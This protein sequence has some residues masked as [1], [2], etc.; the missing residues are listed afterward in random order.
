MADNTL[1]IKIS[2]NVTGAPDIEKLRAAIA[3]IPGVSIDAGKTAG[4]N[5]RR[6][7][8]EAGE[9]ALDVQELT[10]RVLEL[11]GAYEALHAAYD[12]VKEGV[13][14]N[15]GEDQARLGIAALVASL[16]TV[17]NSQGDVLKGA[18]ALEASYG[19]AADQ[20]EKL[21]ADAI[22]TSAQFEQLLN[23]Y[24]KSIAA[25]SNAGLTLDQ[26]RQIVVGVSQAAGAMGVS[27]DEVGS[28]VRQ[29][30]AGNIRVGSEIAKNLG[31][32]NELVN[33]WKEQ[34]TLVENLT[35]RL[36]VFRVAGAE[37]AKSWGGVTSNIK[38]AITQLSGASTV[39][40]T[41]GLRSGMYDAVQT[42]FDPKTGKLSEDFRGL[43]RLLN[44]ASTA[45][46]TALGDAIRGAAALLKEMSKDAEKNRQ[47][48]EQIGAATNQM[49][50]N[51]KGVVAEFFGLF[52]DSSPPFKTIAA[53]LVKLE[54]GISFITATVRD[55]LAILRAINR[56]DFDSLKSA[57]GFGNT[58][59]ALR[60][61]ADQDA[62]IDRAA[63][64]ANLERSRRSA[65]QEQH[66]D[67]YYKAD[68]EAL[69]RAL[70]NR[71]LTQ[72]E[73][74]KKVEEREKEHVKRLAE[75]RGEKPG[76]SSATST[77]TV[78]DTSDDKDDTA[79]AVA[80][81]RLERTR[82]EN[83]EAQDLNQLAYDE[84]KKSYLAYVTEKKR[85]DLDLLESEKRVY[86]EE[87]TAATKTSEQ[88]KAQGKI[89]VL[90]VQ[91]RIVNARALIEEL[92]A[93]QQQTKAN[94][95]LEKAEAE[96]S[97]KIAQAFGEQELATLKVQ[98]EQRLA[99]YRQYGDAKRSL[100]RAAL[101]AQQVAAR[102]ELD[103]IEKVIAGIADPV[104]RAEAEARQV[105]AQAKLAGLYLKGAQA[106][107]TAPYDQAQE[108]ASDAKRGIETAQLALDQ[109][110]ADIAVQVAQGFL[111]EAQAQ[112]QLNAATEKYLADS[113]KYVATLTDLAQTNKNLAP[114]AQ[115]AAIA[116]NALAN[117]ADKTAQSINASLVTGIQGAFDAVLK[118]SRN[119]GQALKGILLTVAQEIQKILTKDIA[120]QIAGV[121]G[122]G[123]GSN[124]GL[125]GLFSS[126]F[127]G[128]FGG[129]G[130]TA[131]AEFAGLFGFAG[132]GPV[133]G[134]GT[135]TS[136][137]VLA[138]LSRGE[139]V[140]KADAVRSVGQST[141]HH[142]NAHGALPRFAAGGLV[143]DTAP[144]AG[145][146]SSIRIVNVLDK[147]LIEDGLTTPGAEKVFLNLIDK[148]ATKIKQKLG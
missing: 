96:A 76:E 55:L 35:E 124:G 69:R 61:A 75:I 95:D 83:K 119:F 89:D 105:L 18:E 104:K 92:K 3:A 139:Y 106:D 117:Q 48:F 6:V 135:S 118:G 32:S 111:T 37:V 8:K 43:T 114:A 64:A 78:V 107:V 39:G 51:L 65:Q 27:M 60:S 7:G 23:A 15:V 103:G 56:L 130:G 142:I 131:A 24:R 9:S 54:Q 71:D 127:G 85:L 137:S 101:E 133:D 34:G 10:K 74:D 46:G 41:E 147:S 16:T 100:D 102:T 129:G 59:D 91:E 25:G 63:I 98:L 112:A 40:L 29:I 68:N 31:L 36:S 12:L 49:L 45:F 11:V 99:T 136:D 70:A 109:R 126:L 73:Y 144:A 26:T 1:Q 28:A 82:A 21:H 33:Q 77:P 17:K 53:T 134:P 84:Q 115:A 47:I 110:K 30:L 62:G 140:V 113:G 128:A 121:F 2:A 93:R 13:K 38:D 146:G 67:E 19:L 20:V 58:R 79:K 123:S 50:V 44:E 57:A 138:R 132:G 4:E 145:L 66:E 97:A 42:V 86:E 80:E 90:A 72:A 122:S 120:E 143:G 116:F 88:I 87:L 5:L 108:D 141:L 14:Y 22:Q 148:H 52:T 81:A 94:A 125:G